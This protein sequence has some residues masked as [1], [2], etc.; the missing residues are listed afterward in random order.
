HSLS[1]AAPDSTG[2]A[3]QRGQAVLPAAARTWWVRSTEEL[4][5]YYNGSVHFCRQSFPRLP[6]FADRPDPRMSDKVSVTVV[7]I[8]TATLEMTKKHAAMRRSW[9][10]AEPLQEGGMQPAVA[11][12]R[13]GG[14]R[15]V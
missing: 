9:S 12:D 3:R 5:D 10:V 14:V 2:S 8:A 13:V 6:A 7:R 4:E 15:I 1:F 11:G